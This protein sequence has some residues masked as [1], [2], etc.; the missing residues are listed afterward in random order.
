MS[1]PNVKPCRSMYLCTYVCTYPWTYLY[2]L[3]NMKTSKFSLT[4]REWWRK[5]LKKIL[6]IIY[7]KAFFAFLWQLHHP[8]Q[9]FRFGTVRES[10]AE[11]YVRQSFPEMHEYMRRYNVPATPDGVQYLKWVFYTLSP[12]CACWHRSPS[13]A[14]A[15]VFF[16]DRQVHPLFVQ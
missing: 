16:D 2:L 14:G 7:I 8:S 10:S 12:R 1:I 4:S 15:F 13:A 5:I 11:D 6:R 9:G 3:I